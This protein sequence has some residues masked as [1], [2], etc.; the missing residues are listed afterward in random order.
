VILNATT[1]LDQ[2]FV[3]LASPLFTSNPTSSPAASNPAD[4]L[5]VIATVYYKYKPGS[6]I[7]IVD[8][9]ISTMTNTYSIITPTIV[10]ASSTT[11]PMSWNTSTNQAIGNPVLK[12]ATKYSARLAIPYT[13]GAALGPQHSIRVSNAPLDL[14][15]PLS[16]VTVSSTGGTV[17][18]TDATGA[19]TQNT[20]TVTGKP[21]LIEWGKSGTNLYYATDAGASTHNLYRVSQ[22]FT[23]VDSTSKGYGGKQHTNL[24]SYGQPT[25]SITYTMNPRCPYRTTLIGTF[26]KKISSM[27]I[28]SNDSLMALTFDDAGGSLV[29][30]STN[31]IRKSNSTNIT[32]TDKTALL[33]TSLKTYCSLLEKGDYKKMFVGTDNGLFF[34]NDIT[35]ASPTWNNVN[36]N[37]LPNVQ[38]FDIKQQTMENYNCYNSGQIFIATNGRGIWTNNDYLASYVVSVNEKEQAK[39]ESRLKLIPNP[40]NGSV[41]VKFEGVQGEVATVHVIDINGRVVKSENLGK[42]ASGQ[43]GIVM[44][45]TDLTSGVYIVNVVSDS[46][47]KR[48]SKLIVTK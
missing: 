35:S 21:Y 10:G 34:T 2:I 40:T 47:I 41:F 27:S 14:N 12:V 7:K 23:I 36:N 28:S 37:Q 18:T 31:D 20:I 6:T 24:F 25:N 19:P 22:V 11:T 3:T 42:L 16:F 29:K 4:Y 45:T 15:T 33:P 5:R 43:S 1:N 32:W 8:A 46:G 26:T 44:E 17:Y 38:I 30:F 9:N 39:A 48:V 13:S